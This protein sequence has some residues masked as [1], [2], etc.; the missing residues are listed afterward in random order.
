MTFPGWS[1]TFKSLAMLVLVLNPD[2]VNSSVHVLPQSGA[3]PDVLAAREPGT[4]YNSHLA[5][6]QVG[7]LLM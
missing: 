2:E 1:E 7:S 6:T 5:L 3:C 4:H